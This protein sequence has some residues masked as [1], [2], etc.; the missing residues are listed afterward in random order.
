MKKY[1]PGAQTTMHI[2]WARVVRKV[3]RLLS[4]V[5]LADVVGVMSVV[6]V[7]VDGSSG[8]GGVMSWLAREYA[9]RSRSPAVAG[10]RYAGHEDVALQ[11]VEDHKQ[12]AAS[13]YVLN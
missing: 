13:K 8:G 6:D 7:G 5:M 11:R 2:V 1:L 9:R 4:V 12:L 3:A 10:R